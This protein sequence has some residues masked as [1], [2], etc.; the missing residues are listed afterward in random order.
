ME[1]RIDPPSSLHAL[2]LETIEQKAR[3][4]I[5]L[6][7]W[8]KAELVGCVFIDEREDILYVGK[9]AISPDHQGKGIGKS[10][11]KACK[12]LAAMNGKNQLELETRIELIENQAFFASQGFSKTG[13][14]AHEGYKKPTSITMRCDLA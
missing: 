13:E 12:D 8:D 4:S 9:L 7:A 5:L 1:D 3:E 10:L 2:T 14:T 6:L 11:I